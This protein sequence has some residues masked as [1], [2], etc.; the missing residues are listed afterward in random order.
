[1]RCPH[2]PPS[3]GGAGG[4]SS[5][6]VERL[7]VQLEPASLDAG[8][9]TDKGYINQRLARERCVDQV[10]LPIAEPR[11]PQVVMCQLMNE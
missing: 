7:V 2:S 10:A 4:G 8:E 11:P 6:V 9:A 5:Q 1:M 3:V